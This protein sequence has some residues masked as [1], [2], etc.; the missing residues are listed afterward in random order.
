MNIEELK[1]VQ[2]GVGI[3]LKIKV[4]G[5]SFYSAKD[6]DTEEEARNF[7]KEHKLE[8]KQIKPLFQS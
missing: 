8:E 7:L 2:I 5:I 4:N 1:I 6:F 3:G